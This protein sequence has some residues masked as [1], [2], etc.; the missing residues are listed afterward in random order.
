MT[1]IVE[2]FVNDPKLNYFLECNKELVTALPT[3]S[4][5]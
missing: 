1:N 3:V 2:K 4:K 5:I